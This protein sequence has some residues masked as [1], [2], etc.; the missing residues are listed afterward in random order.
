MFNKKIIITLFAFILFTACGSVQNVSQGDTNPDTDIAANII[1]SYLFA[2]DFASSG[3][4]MKADSNV[5]AINNTGITGLGSSAIIRSFDGLLYVLHD[6]FSV[7]S[8]DNV[9]V[10]DPSKGFITTKQ[11]STGVGTNPN[12][13][14]VVGSKAFITLY[15]P[16]RNAKV[17]NEDAQPIDLLVIDLTNGSQVKGISFADYLNID[18]S[19]NA[20][21]GQ[22]VLNGNKI[23]VCLQDLDGDSFTHNAPGKIAVIN[24]NTLAIEQVFTLKGRN[25]VDIA[26][27]NNT[28]FIALQA[29]YDFALGDFDT[30]NN[31]GGLEILPLAGGESILLADE[32]LGGYI[33][34]VAV[35]DN[36]VFGVASQF[37]TTSFEYNSTI[38]TLP[39]TAASINDVSTFID[40][41][42]DIRD[43]AVNGNNQ[44]WVARREIKSGEGSASKPQ[45]DVFNAETGV[46]IGS[47]LIPPVPVTSITFTTN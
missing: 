33:E 45:V 2:T 32:D 1:T 16:D 37:D 43:M 8:Y 18:D 47:S 12:D 36:Q 17:V 22:M 30:A 41:S 19:L 23:Y 5:E 10:I 3:Q 34:R 42:A 38:F 6:G 4:L 31:F 13:I 40:N 46:Q 35:S 11:F 20:R 29:P 21:A 27:A 24:V 14:V 25:P 15:S 39:F 7:A 28:L 9:Q 44:L 26:L